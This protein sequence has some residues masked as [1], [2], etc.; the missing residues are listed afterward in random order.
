MYHKPE[1]ITTSIDILMKPFSLNV[2]FV[3]LAILIV[4]MIIFHVSQ[5]VEGEH[6]SCGD[7]GTYILHSASNQ[8]AVWSPSRTSS[9]VIYGFYTVGWVILVATYTGYL[10]SFLSVKKDVI[11]FTTMAESAAN[12]E[13]KLGTLDK[14]YIH[15][16]VALTN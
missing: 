7:Y 10:V 12:T 2:W 5:P 15:S 16:V 9:R 11:P 6:L 4:T 14:S 3:F 13:Y 1:S 8:G